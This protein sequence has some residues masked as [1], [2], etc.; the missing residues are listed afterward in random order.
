MSGPHPYPHLI[1]S[2]ILSRI[3][4]APHTVSG[5]SLTS[6]R[7]AFVSTHPFYPFNARSPMWG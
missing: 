7:T 5:V 6:D 4:E 2:H 1:L 3:I